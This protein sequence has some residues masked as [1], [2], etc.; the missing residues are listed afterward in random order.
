MSSLLAVLLIPPLNA[1]TGI[2]NI[3]TVRT[4]LTRCFHFLIGT[5]CDSSNSSVGARAPGHASTQPLTEKARSDTASRTAVRRG[6]GSLLGRFISSVLPASRKL[7]VLASNVFAQFS[8]AFCPSVLGSTQLQQPG[9][10]AEF[11]MLSGGARTP[12]VVV[13]RG[14]RRGRGLLAKRSLL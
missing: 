12:V 4:H 8:A 1:V 10:A 7:S 9:K 13:T 3:F 6:N 5:G 14:E 2:I 11:I